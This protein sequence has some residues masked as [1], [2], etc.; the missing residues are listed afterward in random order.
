MLH[1]GRHA[2]VSTNLRHV[3]GIKFEMYGALLGTL[4]WGTF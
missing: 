3:A 2:P 4:W 1:H